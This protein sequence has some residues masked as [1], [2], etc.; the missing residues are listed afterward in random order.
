MHSNSG[1]EVVIA[2]VTFTDNR[3][4]GG[5]GFSNEGG[6]RVAITGSRFLTNTAE[7]RGGGILVQ[8]GDVRMFD[9]DVVGNVSKS[10]EEGG[11]GISYAGD[12]SVAVGDSAAIESSRI[13]DNRADG[14]G[15]GID[16]RGDGPLAIIS[17]AITGNTAASGGG[18]HHVGDAPLQV[19][20]STLSGNF[21]ETGGG[22]FADSDGEAVIENTTISGNRAGQLGGGLLVS[23]RVTT[24]NSTIADNNAPSGGGINNG[25][26]P[27]VGD[28]FVFACEHD[29]REQPHGRELRR[30]HHLARRQHRRRRH[31]PARGADGPA[32][33]RPA[34]RPAGRQRR[35][36]ADPRAPGR[37]PGPGQGSVQRAEPLPA[38]DQR[39]VARPRFAGVDIGAYE[40]ELTPGGGGP[41]PCAGRTERPVPSDFDSWVSQSAP[42]SNFGTDAILNVESQSGGNERALVHFDLPPVPPG[43]KLVDATLRLYASSATSGR[44]LEA[45]RLTSAVERARGHLEQPAGHRGPGAPTQSGLDFREWDVLA[46][47]LDMYELGDHGFLIRDRTESGSGAAVLPQQR[48]GHGPAARARAGVRRP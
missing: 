7:E 24:Q 39:G 36:D 3:A 40:S 22:V 1:G 43:C 37:Q 32:R 25:G 38:V 42:G 41:Q 5:G 18:I 6:G 10:P 14:Q 21:A 26:G 35:T 15:G 20:R 9:I 17:T 31:V 45:L 19:V 47:T 27:T 29:R 33:Y 48:E 12:K 46:Q 28:G 2:G 34:P 16:S 8:G 23:S 4:R 30:H 11:G 44:T 13:R